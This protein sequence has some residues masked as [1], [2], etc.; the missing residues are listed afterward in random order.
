MTYR[1]PIGFSNISKRDCER[2]REGERG[3]ER[4]RER[5]G[6][7]ARERERGRER[8]RERERGER[9]REKER[10][11]ENSILKIVDGMSVSIVKSL[12]D[13][14]EV[15]QCLIRTVGASRNAASKKKLVQYMFRDK[16]SDYPD[17][18]EIRLL[19]AGSLPK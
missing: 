13:L 15:S 10:E 4:E 8:A 9:E 12:S 18:N 11:R 14:S 2:E 7:R 5:E 1:N 3:G 19:S 17:I 6:E 16:T